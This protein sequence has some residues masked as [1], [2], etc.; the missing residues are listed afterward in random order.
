M[1]IKQKYWVVEESGQPWRR[2]IGTA[3]GASQLL[4]FYHLHASFGRT[5]NFTLRE[6]CKSE[7]DK[8]I[9]FDELAN[10]LNS[11]EWIC[12]CPEFEERLH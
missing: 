5:A 4:R 7:F 8:L 1:S 6:V 12:L 9:P 10:D 3:K 2:A 11:E